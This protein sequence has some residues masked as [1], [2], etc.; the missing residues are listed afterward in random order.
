MLATV[1]NSIGELVC[2]GQATMPVSSSELGLI[3]SRVTNRLDT[4]SWP[5]TDAARR[6][7]ATGCSTT[8]SSSPTWRSGKITSKTPATNSPP[9]MLA[10]DTRSHNIT[11]ATANPVA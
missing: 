8:Y 11:H 10:A 5:S 1:L 2:M 3:T 9:T 4:T 7:N 6:P